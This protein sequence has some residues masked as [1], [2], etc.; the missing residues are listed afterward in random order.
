[1][2]EKASRLKLRYDY[3]GTCDT[4]DLWDLEVVELDSIFKNLNAELRIQKEESLLEVQSKQVEILEL[5]IAIIKYI[6][7]VKLEEKEAAKLAVFKKERKQK[8]LSILADKQD[9]SLKEMSIEEITKLIEE[10]E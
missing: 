6:V 5:K 2:F 8:L 3:R 4:E 10:T 7:K 9:E 1:M